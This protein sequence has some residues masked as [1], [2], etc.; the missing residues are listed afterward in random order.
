MQQERQPSE[1]DRD[2]VNILQHFVPISLNEMDSVSLLDRYDT[3]YVIQRKQLPEILAEL[4]GEY[5]VLTINNHRIF[6][7]KSLYFDTADYQSYLEHHNRRLPRYKIRY[8]QYVETN[9]SYFEVK[10]KDGKKKTVKSRLP[11]NGISEQLSPIQQALVSEYSPFLAELLQPVLWVLFRR[12]TL[13]NQALTERVTIDVRLQFQAYQQQ[14]YSDYDHLAVLEVKQSRN[15]RES[16]LRQ[17]LRQH[18]IRPTSVSKY[19][20][21]IAGGELGLKSNNFKM[22]LRQLTHMANPSQMPL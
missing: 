10:Q 5:R 13:V 17:V 2:L 21:G 16:A 7:Y 4:L 14:I 6:T 8:R 11:C 15:S 3:K 22:L 20:V 12:M 9:S 1:L 19:C 18:H